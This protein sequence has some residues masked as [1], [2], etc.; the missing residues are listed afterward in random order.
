MFAQLAGANAKQEMMC[1]KIVD[2]DRATP[3]S[4]YQ[5]C[6]DERASPAKAVALSDSQPGLSTSHIMEVLPEADRSGGGRASGQ[7]MGFVEDG[8]W[9]FP[10]DIDS[11]DVNQSRWKMPGKSALKASLHHAMESTIHEP[12]VS[13]FDTLLQQLISPIKRLLTR[14]RPQPPPSAVTGLSAHLAPFSSFAPAPVI[15]EHFEMSAVHGS[16]PLVN[17]EMN[18]SPPPSGQPGYS[19]TAEPSFRASNPSMPP[20]RLERGSPEGGSD[21]MSHRASSPLQ[22]L[23]HAIR[24]RTTNNKWLWTG[25]VIISDMGTFM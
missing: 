5:A 25:S 13:K 10:V 14:S 9:V 20:E 17:L 8:I 12:S 16:T 11:M 24:A 19:V 21:R 23:D 2:A 6:S 3:A 4:D 1:P 15:P 18:P 22:H 7:A